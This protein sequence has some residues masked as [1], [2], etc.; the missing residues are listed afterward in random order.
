VKNNE[1]DLFDYLKNDCGGLI[2]YDGI[3]RI[4]KREKDTVNNGF[5]FLG[6]MKNGKMVRL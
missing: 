3:A 5:Y 4:V 1:P 2:D 6:E